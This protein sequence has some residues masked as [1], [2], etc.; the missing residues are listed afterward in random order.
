MLK[1]LLLSC[2][3]VLLL[4]P[5]MAQHKRRVLIEEFTNASC[6]PCASQNPAFNA[7]VS[8]NAEY[9]TPIKYQTNWPGFDP[10]NEQTQ[11]EVQP[12]VT[13]YGVTGVPNGRQN[14]TLE[15]FPMT[16][17]NSTTIQNGYNNLTPVTMTLSHSL[18]ADYDSILLSLMVTSDDSITGPFRLRVAVTEEAIY[19]DAPPGSN[20]ETEFFNVMRKML[21]NAS[22]TLIDA[23][24]A[25]DT[26]YF[27]FAW[28]LNYIYDLNQLAAVAWI[29]NDANREVL[30]SARTFPI[31]GIGTVGIA[32]A[33]VLNCNAGASPTFQIINNS[34]D[35]LKSAVFRYRVGSG[36]FTDLAWNG[37]LDPGA[38]TDVVI[39]DVVFNT[40]GT[41]KLEVQYV[42]SNTGV[43]T[44]M[45][46]P[47]KII[48][49]RTLLDP[50]VPTPFVHDFQLG[51][52]PP[53]GWTV[54]NP[55]A[56]TGWRLAT[57]AGSGSNR[58]TRCDMFNIAAGLNSELIT[59]H[60]DLNQV[61]GTFKLKFDHAYAY[62]S[63][64]FF[65]SLRI[66]VSTDCGGSWSTIFHDGYQGLATTTPKTTSF[67]PTASMWRANEIDLTPFANNTVLIRF[68]GESG[69]GNNLYIDNINVEF[70]VGTKTLTLDA[71][72]LQPN[73]TRDLANVN[74]SLTKPESIRVLVFNALGA[75]VQSE[76]LGDLPAGSHQVQLDAARLN[77][78]NYRVV[79]QGREGIAQTQ[80][81]IMK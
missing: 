29:Q 19:F 76:E 77:S 50:S 75:L 22:G 72:T 6:G 59:P 11:A 28:K 33:N 25:G 56:S 2:F 39:N 12:R 80:W 46:A 74:F 43:Q 17:Y 32:S 13:Y 52:A 68:S 16:S 1:N 24:P 30:Q 26:L 49:I 71:F 31:G 4:T 61:D 79:L 64:T 23:L 78:G 55:T 60:I 10:M 38:S 57:N 47:T 54:F 81:V 8:A 20:G 51:S 9:L 45:V 40:S 34:N 62:Y 3:A 70:L 27:D 15:V 58:S 14:G 21:P 36:A 48:N 5:A 53:P 42:S 7:V 35:T 69:F 44:N 65:D 63:S 66:D 41:A 67:T 73:P 37:I 18:T